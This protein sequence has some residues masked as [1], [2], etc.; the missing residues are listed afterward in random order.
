VGRTL[1]TVLVKIKA[2]SEQTH[3]RQE[4]HRSLFGYRGD[5]RQWAG[6]TGTRGASD[7]MPSSLLCLPPRWAVSKDAIHESDMVAGW[8]RCFVHFGSRRGERCRQSI[9]SLAELEIDPRQIDAFNTAVREVGQV[10]V[11]VEEGCLALYA[12]ADSD[13]PSRLHVFE[14]YRDSAAYQAHLQTPHFQRF[15]A[16]TNS[17]VLSRKLLDATP[18]SIATKPGFTP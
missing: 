4:R 7:R 18:V 13:N 12:V 15:R 9:H 10:S 2:R 6:W 16:T 5:V 3:N 14:I 8:I 11:R 17:M 1:S